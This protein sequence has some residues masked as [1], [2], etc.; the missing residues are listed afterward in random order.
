MNFAFIGGKE[1]GKSTLGTHHALSLNFPIIVFDPRSQFEI[2]PSVA[3]PSEAVQIWLSEGTH[4]VFRPSGDV[5]AEEQEFDMLVAEMRPGLD[6]KIPVTLLVDESDRLK[7]S[8]GLNFMLRRTQKSRCHTMLLSHRMVDYS[9]LFRGQTD[10]FY[11]FAAHAM[12][13]LKEIREFSNPL[14]AEMVRYLKRYEYVVYDPVDGT[15]HFVSNE[16]RKQWWIDIHKPLS[17]PVETENA[18]MKGA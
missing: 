10:R 4:V 11:F 15:H 2:F 12:A 18:G 13:D 17:V 6:A 8:S 9:V 7:R 1:H 5:A 16:L 3:D 14:V